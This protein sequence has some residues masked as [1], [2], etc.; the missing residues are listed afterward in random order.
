MINPPPFFSIVMP[1][2]NEQRHVEQA[3]LSLIRQIGGRDAEILVMDGGSEDDTPGIV[4]RLACHFP[5]IRL[6]D[7][8]ERIQSAACN[9]AAAMLDPRST[10]MI[11][12]DAHAAYPTNFVEEVVRALLTTGATSVVVPMR[13]VGRSTLQRAIAA[14]QNSRLGNGGS[15]HRRASLSRFVDHGHHAAFDVAFFR[16]IGGYD[17]SFTHNEDAEFDVRTHAAGGRVWL[18]AEATIDYFP[19]ET[20]RQLARQYS[21]YGHGRA[22]TVIKHSLALRPRQ[23]APFAVLSSMAAD[24]LAPVTPWAMM[25]SGLYVGL[26]LFWGTAAAVRHRDAALLLMGPA[27]VT[28]HLCWAMGFIGA[29]RRLVPATGTGLAGLSKKLRRA[30]EPR[31][32]PQVEA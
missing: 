9:R 16:S 12:T 17:P 19:R 32:T 21:R 2:L 27:A 11:R 1:V 7:N 31:K 26:C 3:L 4:S 14:T 20:L 15:A 30:I 25:P 10:I 13:T 29:Q 24:L 8:P 23:L 18:C 5:V 22:R 28:M 6:V